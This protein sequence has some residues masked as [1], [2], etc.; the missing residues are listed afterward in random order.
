ML[1]L[2][3]HWLDMLTTIAALHLGYSEVGA[4]G[5]P[6]YAA[7]GMAGLFALTAVGPLFELAV[8]AVMPRQVLYVGWA[9]VLGGEVFAVV[10]NAGL[11]IRA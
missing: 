10:A 1:L 5:R 3:L 7:Y 8:I 4:L 2:T 6:L 9:I 11:L